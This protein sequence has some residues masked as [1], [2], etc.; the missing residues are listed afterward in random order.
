METREHALL[1][2][3]GAHRW[4]KCPVSARLENLIEDK[5]TKYS[6]EGTLAHSLAEKILSG[7]TVTFPNEEME[8]AVMTY[9]NYVNDLYAS[10]KE[11]DELTK[12]H[13]EV[14]LDFSE[15]VP[16]GFGTGDTVIISMDE[17]HIIDYKHG[18]NV[19]VEVNDNPQLK[20]Y[21]LGGL[22]E[23][24]YLFNIEKVV[25]HIVQPRMN[26]IGMFSILPKDL[27]AWGD[28]VF[29]LAEKA[30]NGEGEAIPGEYCQFCK[31][32]GICK[33][34]ANFALDLAK[35]GT[36]FKLIAIEDYA[37]IYQACD[38][39]KSF[40]SAFE[41]YLLQEMQKGKKIPG[42]KLVAKRSVSTYADQTAV[43]EKL[44]ELGFED[45]L[46]HKPRELLGLT[47]MKKV[48]KTKGYKELENN[49]LIIKPIGSPTVA[50]ES[51]P[52]PAL[53]SI[54]EYFEEII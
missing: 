21:G 17:L 28:E 36:D 9:V 7:Q 1:S 11:K 44:K 26:N 25:L 5:D 54:I 37:S 20:L 41:R 43:E 29:K 6:E 15:Y 35:K 19:Y 13:H 18:A 22:I 27:K 10:L 34:R 31:V 33:A 32:A 16:E 24:D 52:R 23:F 45:A 47:E 8:Q 14:R 39:A 42:L 48:I 53:E 2:A 4:L 46:I 3:S 30:F 50:L 40:A 38:I 49:G 12:K 51:D